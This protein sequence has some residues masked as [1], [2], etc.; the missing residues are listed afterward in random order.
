MW[1]GRLIKNYLMRDCTW[2]WIVPCSVLL[3][4]PRTVSSGSLSF[5]RPGVFQRGAQGYCHTEVSPGTPADAPLL[6]GMPKEIQ[7]SLPRGLWTWG[8]GFGVASAS[9][10]LCLHVLSVLH[11]FKLGGDTLL[12]CRAT[13]QQTFGSW[14]GLGRAGRCVCTLFFLFLLLFTQAS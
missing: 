9:W 14:A 12:S 10:F 1:G 13:S 6:C 5:S 11:G 8:L 7:N 2:L 3:C 4:S